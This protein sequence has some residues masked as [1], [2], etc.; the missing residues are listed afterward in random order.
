MTFPVGALPNAGQVADLQRVVRPMK[1][2][3]FAGGGSDMDLTDQ[4]TNK[5][6]PCATEFLCTTSG[7]LVAA[8]AGDVKADNTYTTQSYPL[9]AGDLL[10]GL[11]VIAKGTS[12]ASGI[13]RQ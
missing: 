4:A 1:A 7:N 10:P 5:L 3:A 11:F 8:M 9:I 6:G 2:V 12:T 13:F